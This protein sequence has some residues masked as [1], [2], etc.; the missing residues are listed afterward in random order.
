MKVQRKILGNE[1][2]N[3]LDGIAI[4]GL[5]YSLN[6]RWDDAKK[7][8]VEVIETSKTKL[9]WTTLPHL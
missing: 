4:V 3:T 8:E 7:L 1:C 2:S 9:E 6:S 5:A